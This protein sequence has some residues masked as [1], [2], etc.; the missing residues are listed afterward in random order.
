M[1]V[2][3]L[4][5]ITWKVSQ[6]LRQ[7]EDEDTQALKAATRSLRPPDLIAI[8]LH[9]P[10]QASALWKA[11]L[12][13][14]FLSDA[15]GSGRYIEVANVE[16][17]SSY[18][19]V[20]ALERS[21]PAQVVVGSFDERGVCSTTAQLT[22]RSGDGQR[23][24]L[25]AN[26]GWPKG[27]RNHTSRVESSFY[28]LS[29]SYKAAGGVLEGDGKLYT[30]EAGKARL[31]AISLRDG[32]SSDALLR[33]GGAAVGENDVVVVLGGLESRIQDGKDQL[34]VSMKN[35][36]CLPAFSDTDTKAANITSYFDHADASH[37]AQPL[38][39]RHNGRTSRI[40]YHAWGAEVDSCPVSSR[41]ALFNRVTHRPLAS[42]LDLSIKPSHPDTYQPRTEQYAMSLKKAYAAFRVY[43]A[44]EKEKAIED[45]VS[46]G[47]TSDDSAEYRGETVQQVP[48]GFTEL[49]EQVVSDI[50][51]EAK[52]KEPQPESSP[53]KN[54]LLQKYM[55]EPQ[56]V[57]AELFFEPY[58][59]PTPREEDRNKS[60]SYVKS[61]SLVPD[62][63]K[64]L[65]EGPHGTPAGSEVSYPVNESLNTTALHTTQTKGAYSPTYYLPPWFTLLWSVSRDAYAAGE[66]HTQN[67]EEVAM[68]TLYSEEYYDMLHERGRLMEATKQKIRERELSKRE[69]EE[70]AELRNKPVITR[71]ARNLPGRGE[72]YR[73]TDEWKRRSQMEREA[74]LLDRQKQE[75]QL[76]VESKASMSANSHKI[77]ERSGEAYKSPVADWHHHAIEHFSKRHQ[78]QPPGGVFEPVL[79]PK[80]YELGA[81]ERPSIYDRTIKSQ[82]ETERKLEKKRRMQEEE[83][84]SHLKKVYKDPNAKDVV[85]KMLSKTAERTRKFNRKAQKLKEEECPAKPQLNPR[86]LDIVNRRPRVGVA[87]SRSVSTERREVNPVGYVGP[88]K[89]VRTEEEILAAAKK[90]SNIETVQ[91]ARRKTEKKIMKQRGEETFSHKPTISAHS[92]ALAK[93]REASFK[94]DDLPD[95]MEEEFIVDPLP[96]RTV[97]ATTTRARSRSRSADKLTTGELL[98]RP[99]S[100][101]TLQYSTPPTDHHM[102]RSPQFFTPLNT[103]SASWLVPQERYQSTANSTHLFLQQQHTPQ[104]LPSY[105][106][107]RSKATVTTPHQDPYEAIEQHL[108]TMCSVLD[109]YRNLEDYASS[110]ADGV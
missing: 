47:W 104:D 78:H 10:A 5:A 81:K 69:Q 11:F 79:N 9:G 91:A 35:E 40:L 105:P 108:S 68:A 20:H 3:K 73:Y 57:P 30:T 100:G 97:T 51:E 17:G 28:C 26:W 36:H 106:S 45:D 82:K 60:P 42:I 25:I 41:A 75:E 70:L 48:P 77:I 44:K 55:D 86:S 6:D 66:I 2:L 29:E 109:E 59:P 53:Y 64:G 90:M 98:S 54:P 23:R 27:V 18:L 65:P 12:C 43:S 31:H 99:R 22:Y 80:S 95:R 89:I 72:F 52:P 110:V 15:S 92:R 1:E 56:E 37:T 76:L 96:E 58:Y 93:A 8:G 50:K 16:R 24:I 84:N 83:E 4:A 85:D 62:Q 39:T 19:S 7:P 102:S 61:A 63:P 49:R 87:K 33:E 107:Q 46:D 38:P 71:E 103:V 67:I 13:K 101:T 32:A 74:K 94:P 88:R 14:F 21:A 34:A